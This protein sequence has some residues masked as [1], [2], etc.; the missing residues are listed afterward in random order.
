MNF[1]LL[2]KLESFK[3]PFFTIGDLEKIFKAK[4]KSLRVSLARLVKSGMLSRLRRGIYILST[5]PVEADKI[6]AQVFQPSY[7]SF[8]SA[9][10]R[11]GILSQV[12]YTV[13]LASPRL[14]LSA[15]FGNMAVEIR[16]IRKDLF[17]DY[18]L[19]D[20]VLIASPE[21][22]LVDMLYLVSL[23][24][25]SFDSSELDLKGISKKKAFELSKR[26]PKSTQKLLR[27]LLRL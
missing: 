10:S 4:R 11:Y 9:L 8:E 1:K 3:K 5:K 16:R 20:G 15:Q 2:Q 27:K 18:T 6:A 13:T 7:I 25:S 19:K 21:K 23:G 24:K 22:A 12:P 14:S 17:S 26:Y